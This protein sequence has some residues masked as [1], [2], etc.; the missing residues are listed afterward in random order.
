MRV[1]I[2]SVIIVSP[3]YLFLAQG[4]NN[5]FYVPT[6]TELA[7]YDYVETLPKDSLIGGEPCAL[8]SVPFYAKRDILFSCER[9]KYLKNPTTIEAMLTA[10]YAE[11]RTA[12]HQF[13]QEYKID[14]LIVDE[15]KFSPEFVAK[16]LFFYQP[17]NEQIVRQ[18]SEQSSFALAHIPD[19]KKMFQAD[20]IFVIPCTSEILSH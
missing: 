18:I 2:V 19:D 9:F 4:L 3:L 12:V 7:L 20:S 1:F 8:D 15:S 6:E 11:E 13:C 14:Y 5:S 10:Y 17:Y 16:E